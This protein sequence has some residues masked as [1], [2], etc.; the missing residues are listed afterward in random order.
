MNPDPISSVTLIEVVDDER[1]LVLRGRGLAD[2]SCPIQAYTKITIWRIQR[3]KRHSKTGS[4]Q[5]KFVLRFAVI[6][7][8]L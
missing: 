5:Y 2:V 4:S 1:L 7:H 8:H 3:M 6:I